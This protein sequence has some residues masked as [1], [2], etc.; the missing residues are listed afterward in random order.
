MKKLLLLLPVLLTA[1]PAQ[2]AYGF[3]LPRAQEA[4]L[5]C[6]EEQTEKNCNLAVES[7]TNLGSYSG[8]K[9]NSQCGTPAKVSGANAILWSMGVTP[10]QEEKIVIYENLEKMQQFC[11]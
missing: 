6:L 4:T 11:K 2:A 10:S 8:S 1:S 5:L 3:L 9:G 7:L